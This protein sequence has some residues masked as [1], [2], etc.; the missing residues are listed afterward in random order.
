MARLSD[1]ADCHIV[2]CADAAGTVFFHPSRVAAPRRL[3]GPVDD[4]PA[5]DGQVIARLL[6]G[7]GHRDERRNQSQTEEDRSHR[8]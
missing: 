7:I 3:T 8:G 5:D 1:A 4:L 6:T 2:R